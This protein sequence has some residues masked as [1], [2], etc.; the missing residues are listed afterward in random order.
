[1]IIGQEYSQVNQQQ[2]GQMYQQQ[3]PSQQCKKFFNI[4]LFPLDYILQQPV[5]Q[6]NMQNQQ[7]YFKQDNKPMVNMADKMQIA[8]SSSTQ[9]LDLRKTKIC[10]VIKQGVSIL[11]QFLI[12]Q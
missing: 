9:T 8:Q 11:P 3:P 6:Q 4:Y 2:Q 10:P 5:Q 7:M 12:K 1:M